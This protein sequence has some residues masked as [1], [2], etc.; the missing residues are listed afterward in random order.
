M[1]NQSFHPRKIR[2][3]ESPQLNSDELKD[4]TI[5]ALNKLGSQ[6]F[7][8][9]TGGYSLGNWARGMNILLDD[10]EEKMGEERLP[11][12]YFAKRRELNEI[13]SKPA[14]TP[15][16]DKEIAEIKQDIADANNKIEAETGRLDSKIAELTQERAGCSAELTREQEMISNQAAERSSGSFLRRLIARNPKGSHGAKDTVEEL[17][18]KLRALD[19]DILE[20]QKLMKSIERQSPESP[21]GEDWKTLES[22]QGRL[23]ALQGARSESVKFVKAREEFTASIAETISKIPS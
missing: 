22:L 11:A 1:K 3:P 13:L 21:F 2:I 5:I 14:S 18:E 16:L 6:K 9:E 7:S 20:Q 19:Q 15:L 8:D 4:R 12:D 10:F 17:K 23:D